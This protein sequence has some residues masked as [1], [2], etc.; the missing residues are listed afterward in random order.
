MTRPK[1]LF[2][3]V[4]RLLLAAITLTLIGAM[5]GCIYEASERCSGLQVYDDKSESCICPASAPVQG[6]AC[7]PCTTG[8]T[9]P[10][11]AS[12]PSG[13][14]TPCTTDTDC[15]GFDASHCETLQ[16]HVC[17]VSPC[18]KSPDSCTGGQSCCDLSGLGLPLTLCLPPGQCPVQ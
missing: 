5:P 12:G 8:D 7:V 1:R 4:P 9:R 2:K 6:S 13:F 18:Q 11:C 15:A 14:G 16:G 17:V 10:A 3:G